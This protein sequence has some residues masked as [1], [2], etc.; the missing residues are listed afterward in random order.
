[1]QNTQNLNDNANNEGHANSDIP[2]TEGRGNQD[3]RATQ[4]EAQRHSGVK[5]KVAFAS[6]NIKGR[7]SGE[8][9][10]WMHIPQVMRERRIGVMAIQETHMTDELADQFETL[11]G[12]RFALLHSPDPLT[13]NA[14]GVALILNK[15]LIKTSDVE[16]IT[17][18]PG[19]AISVSL[20]W[21][22]S[23]RVNVMAIYAPN[24]PGEIRDF[25][26]VI[27]EKVTSNPELKPDVVMGDFNLVEDALDRIP[28]KPDDQRA[29]EKLREFRARYGL[30]DGW[31]KANP[32]EKGYSWA[33]ES[34]GTQSRLDRIY[35][36]RSFFAD[37][38]DWRIDP[39]PIP[40]D[41]DIVSAKIATPTSPE[42]GRGRWAIPTRL[43]KN[44][45][46]KE[47]IQRMGR[48]LED[49][50]MSLAPRTQDVNPQSL[51]REFKVKIREMIRV[52][53]KR[54]QPMVKKRIAN[55]TDKLRRVINDP[56]LPADEIKISSIHIRKEIQRLL[57]E[58]HQ[59]NRDI[60]SAIDEA[61]GEKIGKTWSN[62]AKES[63][64]R[65]TIKRL[66]DP[67]TDTLTSESAKMAQITASYHDKLQH[68]G[69]D[70]QLA[71]D[72]A[73]LNEI[74]NQ[75]KTK[76]SE[77]SK[78]MLREEI[79]E[80]EIREAIKKTNN[81]K[82]PG[83]DGIPI[84]LWKSLDDQYMSDK[85]SPKKKCNIIWILT[86]VFRD[87]EVS[88]M[89]DSASLNEGCINPIYKK[90][91]PDD[92][93]NYRP[94]TL[95]NTDYK[96]YTKALSLRLADAV[97]EIINTDQ[98]GF[99]RNRNIFDQV[100]TTKLVIDY[101]C[102]ANK[103]GA[104]IALDQEKAYDKIL[105]PYLWK[106][107]E[108]FEFPAE[109]I[110]IIQSL[111]DNAE[112][113]VMV[114]GEL[115]QPFLVRRGV[116]QGDAL[117][118]LLFDIAIEPLAERIRKSRDIE[119]VRIPGTRRFLKIKLFA[120]D[121]TVFLSSNDSI[122]KLQQTLSEWCAVSGA[123]FNMEKTEIIPTGNPAQRTEIMNTRKLDEGSAELPPTV[124]IAKEGEPVRILGAWLGNGV[125][126]SMTWAPILENVCKRLRN[127]GAAKHS[128]EGRRLIVQ[129]QVAGVTQY[130]T[131]VQGM[132]CE[133]EA[134][135]NKQIRRFTW[136]NEK[137]DTVNRYQ[138]YAPHKKGGKKLL[139]L[140]ARNK[141]IHL[142]WLKAYLNLGADRATWTY[143]ADAI[144]GTD[145]P[146]SHQIDGDPESRIMPILQTWNPKVRGSSLPE[147]LKQ[148]LKLARE[149]NVRV[150]A[151]NPSKEAKEAM[152]IW[153]HIHSDQSA[154]RL[155]KSK[156][157]K[158]LR[159]KHNMRLVRDAI[160]ALETTGED[161]VPRNNCTCEACKSLR[162]E[163]GCTHTHECINLMAT[164]VSKI[165]PKWNP[166]T[167][168]SP[169]PAV[170][171]NEELTLE[172]GETVV[173]KVDPE[174]N[175]REVITIFNED[176]LTQQTTPVTPLMR[177]GEPQTVMVWTDGACINN[178]RE[179]AAAG[180]G[181]W[182]SEDDP[183]NRSI[184]VPIRAQSNQTGEL[185][186][187]LIAVRENASEDNLRII[188][189]SKY[190]IDGLTKHARRWENKNWAGNQHGPLFRCITA[191][192]RW[193]KG[194]T[195]LRWTKG[196]N[197][198]RGNEGADKLAGEGAKKPFYEDP[199]TLIAPPGLTA[200]GAKLSELEQ[201]DFYKII[202]GRR[203]IPPRTRTTRIVG[204][205]QACTE[206]TFGTSPKEEAIWIATRH[207]DLTRK[208]RDFL[209]K[210]TQHAYK[211]GEYWNNIPGYE[212]RGVCPLC[213]TQEDMEHILT[214]CGAKA[215]SAAWGLANKLWATRSNSPLPTNLGDILG[216]G[217]AEFQR[218]GRP[219]DGK[220]RLYR[221]ILSE[222]AYL[223]WK[224]RNERRIQDEDG[225]EH[226][227]VIEETTRRWRKT[228]N[229]RL[230]IDRH[231]TDNKR[232]GKRAV[233]PELVKWTW[234]GTLENEENLPTDWHVV[235][236]GFSGYL[237]GVSPRIR[238]E[239]L[240]PTDARSPTQSREA[241]SA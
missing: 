140:E 33:R 174:C 67:E 125:D 39:P 199:G 31:R 121:T 37:C 64:P 24:A 2:R 143:F 226:D 30:V 93:A 162:A 184:R 203:K 59:K 178:G 66:R 107:M 138:M 219:D 72:E 50:L 58:T 10:K 120:D 46:I 209:W 83:L 28:S 141:A 89:D 131:K 88:G 213:D 163:H 98:A 21:Q 22:D 40:T 48:D 153:Y 77:E 220:N 123:R 43:L 224:M 234:K 132:P 74:L 1:V 150:E 194:T 206:S 236:G 86:Q 100:K 128:L 208:T 97:P 198:D 25:W 20:P 12:N 55:L 52:H 192:I 215:R 145:I 122:E 95:L 68:D 161:H 112:T 238:Q 65:D 228:M 191:W 53:E 94:I 173:S 61:E 225:A 106:V 175:L 14:K 146:N 217:L 167:V 169:N 42:M 151:S 9:D 96:I 186:A 49:R 158:C 36:H 85:T 38:A 102:R 90:K 11:F 15:R 124:H 41:H 116:R 70:P 45:L 221:I 110:R 60:L 84:E 117:S 18:V 62:R 69:H 241:A 232:F 183:R 75:V 144:I 47:E 229:K 177:E 171:V 222:T 129:M 201:R 108:K 73:G 155:Y 16:L 127:W 240:G 189:D 154:R 26:N 207:K 103:R 126:Q 8:I 165:L 190:V 32:E 91:D 111:Y 54:I 205:I 13:R 212:G 166:K 152:P 118:C 114:N 148:M 92:A 79:S 170:T 44:K 216:C 211:V 4:N 200:R 214:E 56:G 218:N 193:R 71:P 135:L 159:K 185:I 51:L 82:A 168:D 235:K 81:E 237:A 5:A 80:G 187:V 115:S 104:V 164:L 156:T 231:L 223:I 176:P 101:M 227:N 27:T 7:R 142:T 195:T 182:Y 34:D 181:I 130:L 105:H 147:D 76:L 134:Q 157:A 63:K 210:S 239:G 6:L 119:G 78:R 204:R 188:S 113:T 137:V 57:K 197:G 196:H 160:R 136:N 19:R 99:I 23:L 180:S 87:I 17:L 29:T 230:T 202:S 139:D 109:F 149:Y 233:K 3:S 179:N 133:I 172:A 35:V